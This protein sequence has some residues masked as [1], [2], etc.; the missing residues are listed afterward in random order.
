M[1]PWNSLIASRPIVLH[2]N[3]GPR[4][5][6]AESIASRHVGFVVG[7]DLG[8]IPFIG[9]Y[10]TLEVETAPTLRLLILKRDL[11]VGLLTNGEPF[12]RQLFKE[13]T[14]VPLD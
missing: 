10:L 2:Q 12:C 4:Q 3:S 13:F 8:H 1:A 5:D 7:F 14:K 9:T 6:G 11:G